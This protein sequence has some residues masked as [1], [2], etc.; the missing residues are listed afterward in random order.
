VRHVVPPEADASSGG[1]A[2]IARLFITNEWGLNGVSCHRQECAQ[3]R[4]LH[5]RIRPDEF[6]KS[7]PTKGEALLSQFWE[8]P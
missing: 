4:E 1:E 8:F 6:F 5:T 2:S 7:R 3:L